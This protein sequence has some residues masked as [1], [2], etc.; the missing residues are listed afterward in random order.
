MFL[1]SFDRPNIRYLVR[2]KEEA[3]TQLLRFLEQHRGEAGIVYARSR[4]RVD[5]FAAEL[6]AAGFDAVAYHAGL[7]ASSGGRHWHAAAF[8]QRQ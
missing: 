7:G 5:R 2:A 4:S 3:K 6:R 1:A 8:P